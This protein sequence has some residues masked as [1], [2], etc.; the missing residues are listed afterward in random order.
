MTSSS[1]SARRTWASCSAATPRG[2][3]GQFYCAFYGPGDLDGVARS[4]ATSI[5]TP[6]ARPVQA[7]V[8]P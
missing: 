3:R 7:L 1:T 5:R 8:R 4:N 2:A 6:G